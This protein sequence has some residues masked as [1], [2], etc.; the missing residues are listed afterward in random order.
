MT[1]RKWFG[2]ALL[3]ALLLA[4]SLP[5]LAQSGP[6]FDLGWHVIGGG[7]RP[8]TSAHYAVNGT[9]GQAAAAP[10]LASGPHYVVSGGFWYTAPSLTYLPTL[11]KS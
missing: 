7:G 11:T 1:P 2:V 8:V 4:V 10:P 5:V 9:A 3:L 6:H